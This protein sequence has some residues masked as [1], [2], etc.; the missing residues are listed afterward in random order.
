[1]RR[2]S[3]SGFL[4]VPAAAALMADMAAP[5]EADAEP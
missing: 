1:M 5:L 2:R 3:L 4:I